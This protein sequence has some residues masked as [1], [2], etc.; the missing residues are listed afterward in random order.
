LNPSLDGCDAGGTRARIRA[1]DKVIQTRNDYALGIMNGDVGFVRALRD[2]ERGRKVFSVAFDAVDAA[3]RSE[4]IVEIA[5]TTEGEPGVGTTYHSVARDMGRKAKH[6]FEITE[7][8]RPTRIRWRETSKG[9]VIVSEGGYDLKSVDGATEL[10]FFGVLEGRGL[11]KLL[12]PAV[13][14]YVRRL[15]P[16]FSRKLTDVVE[17][18][19]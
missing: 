1:G 14:R 19:V 2:D 6:D 13:A 7:F 8:D 9:P 17:A 4:R 18:S 16:E 3:S 11:G 12:E 5:Q 15:L 10:G